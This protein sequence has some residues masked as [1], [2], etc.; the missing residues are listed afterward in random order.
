MCTHRS[1]LRLL[2]LLMIAFTL[3]ATACFAAGKVSTDSPYVFTDGKAAILI[4][5]TQD[6]PGK[7]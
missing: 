6:F 4:P 2:I 3:S 7:A 1:P 5:D